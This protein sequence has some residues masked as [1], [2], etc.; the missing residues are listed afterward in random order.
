[1]RKSTTRSHAQRE[2]RAIVARRFVAVV[3]LTAVAIGLQSTQGCGDSKESPERVARKSLESPRRPA[4]PVSETVR[5]IEPVTVAETQVE[6]DTIEAEHAEE[7]MPTAPQQSPQTAW[8]WYLRGLELRRTGEIDSA[9]IS[10]QRAVEISP[11][12]VKGWLNLA[13]V[14]LDL[15]DTSQAFDAATRATALD[16]SSPDA[17]VV[18]ARVLYNQTRVD[19]AVSAYER[20][21]A[22]D[23][24]NPFAHNNLGLIYIEQERFEVALPHLQRAVALRDDLPFFFNNLGIT[25]ERLGEVEEA[26]AAYTKAVELDPNNT[27]A[28]AN[29][30]RVKGLLMQQ[31]DT[32]ITLQNDER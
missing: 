29:L 13:R 4:T 19:E 22:L 17:W 11:D 28:Q 27:K 3:F 20:A 1:M 9:R 25:L 7:A 16:S 23:S 10:L 6:P 5:T 24:E 32:R 18:L 8:Q 30:E 26:K 12:F 15:G 14:D 2:S 31:K 21:I